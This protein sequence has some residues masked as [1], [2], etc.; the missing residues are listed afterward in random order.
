MTTQ[1]QYIERLKELTTTK[2]GRVIAGVEEYTALAEA[3]AEATGIQLD[4]PSLK[5]LFTHTSYAISPRPTTLSALARYVGY[6]GWTDFCTSRDVLPAEDEE[7][8][9]IVRRWGMIAGAVL[10]AVT[11]IISIAVIIIHREEPMTE[12][13]KLYSAVDE[14]FHG[15][16]NRWTAATTEHCNEMRTYYDESDMASYRKI[17]AER[18]DEFMVNLYAE[19][20][21]DITLYAVEHNITVDNATIDRTADAIAALCQSM[22]DNLIK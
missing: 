18:N 7:K 16:K 14:R 8:I 17:V 5:H 20:G 10:A 13:E 9:P 1:E 21:E 3:V 15:V 12:A 4:V 22:C 6:G 11:L 2:F 19:I